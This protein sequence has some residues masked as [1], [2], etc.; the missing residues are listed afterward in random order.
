MRASHPLEPQTQR[1]GRP[2][3]AQVVGIFE[4]SY[5]SEQ[6]NVATTLNNLA[7]LLF[8]INRLGEAEPLMRRNAEILMAFSQQGFQ[9]PNLEAALSNYR[10]LLQALDLSESE[11]QA[12][13]QGLLP[14]P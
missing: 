1:K 12:K 9:H 10:F 13:L 3:P 11:V 8:S 5:G 4:A 2:Q 14:S 6:P 7:S